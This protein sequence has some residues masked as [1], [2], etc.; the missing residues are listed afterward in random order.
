MDITDLSA[1]GMVEA[2]ARQ[3]E[4]LD[5]QGSDEMMRLKRDLE[6]FPDDASQWFDLGLAISQAAIQRDQLVVEQARMKLAV[7]AAKAAAERPEEESEAAEEE[8]ELELD[9]STVDL[10]GSVPMTEEALAA[11]DKVLQLEPDYY[12]VQTQKGILLANLH[13]YD[14][15]ERCFLQA[16]EDDEEDFSAAYYLA[17]AYRDRG[18]DAEAEKYFALAAELNPDDEAFC[19]CR[20]EQVER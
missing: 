18:N 7:E 11:F 12:G 16:L 10:S 1:E 6:K 3:I 17:L 20:G 15:A 14:E 5:T 2:I 8:E 19:N 9:L 13:R 4:K